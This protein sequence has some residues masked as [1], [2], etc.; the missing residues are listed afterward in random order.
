M[1]N[2]LVFTARPGKNY[3]EQIPRDVKGRA[4]AV[5]AEGKIYD[6][7]LSPEREVEAQVVT[8]DSEEGIRILRHSAAHLLAQAVTELYP[9]ALPNAG[10]VTEDGFYYDIFMDPISSQ[11]LERIEER[12]R[13]IASRDIPIVREVHSR[14]ELLSIFSCNRFK[15]DKIR[16]NVPEGGQSTVYRQGEFVDFCQGPHVPS[17]GYLKHVKLLS[18]ASTNYLGDPSRERLIRIYGTAFPDEKSLKQYLKN[19]E[20]ALRR[21]HR[22][23][24][25]EMDL[26]VFNS[27]RAPGFP[28][29]TPYGAAIRNELIQYMRD[30]NREN[31]WLEVSTPHIFRDTIWKQSGHYAKYRPN[32]YVFQLE[33]GDGYGVKPMNCPGHITIFE[34]RMYSFREMPVKLCEAGTVYRYEKS[35]EVGGLTRPRMFTIDDGHAFLRKDQIQEEVI[36]ILRM[37]TRTFREILG[38]TDMKFDLSVIDREHPENYLLSYRCHSC[39]SVS[40]IRAASLQGELACPVCGSREIEPDFSAWDEATEQLRK[41]LESLNIQYK[42]YPGEA[43]FY[44]PKIDV[45]V[46]DALGRYWQF[47]TVQ[48]D[49]F[50]PINFDLTYVGSGGSKERVVMIHRA[51]YGSYERFMAL[52]LE[53]FAGK[54]PTWLSPIQVYITP[55]SNS[56]DDYAAEVSRALSREGIRVELDT[57]PETVAKKIRMIRQKRP[58]YIVVVG[59]RERSSGSVTVRNRKDQQNSYG[60]SEFIS[61]LKEEIRERNLE[62]TL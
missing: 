50:M 6:L 38:I 25:E 62:Q 10:P 11:D 5:M 56:Y 46:K 57:S 41:A 51:I 60:L 43:A 32:M 40:E 55:V 8:Q 58:A 59:E 18:V 24:G 34:R 4:V 15:L 21:D 53:N 31:G 36:S 35:G 49:F 28:L 9:G 20:E 54:L 39:S 26:F 17:T 27:E 16:A 30:L 12:M 13:E 52:L 22:R 37:I 2:S 48:L 14:Q 19:R 47:S 23:I 1:T 61:R 3:M 7:R 44:G 29:Y 45:H 42:E 33:D